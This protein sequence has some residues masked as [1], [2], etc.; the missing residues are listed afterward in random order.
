MTFIDW[1]D[2]EE[3]FGLLIEYV[4]DEQ[5]EASSDPE[6][7]KFLSGLINDFT[8]LK[9]QFN[10]LSGAAVVG[11]LKSISDSIDPE[12]KSDPVVA[13]VQDCIAELERLNSQQP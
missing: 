6:R 1:S 9:K 8:E 11:E 12:F 2:S 10:T 4:Q 3:L 13:H 7:R 5:A